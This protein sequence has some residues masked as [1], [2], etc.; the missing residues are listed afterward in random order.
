MSRTRLP[1]HEHFQNFPEIDPDDSLIGPGD[2]PPYM[3]YHDHG[4]APVLLV[5][6]HASPF[7]PASLNQLGLAD[8]VL[9]Q[10][11]A[12]D[13][14]VDELARFLADELD[15]QLVLAG[16]SRL[17]V[18]PNRRPDDPSAIPSISDGIAIPGNQDL[19]EQQRARRLHSFFWPY[20]NAI[21]ERLDRFSERGVVP[22]V[23]AVH[24]CTPV[25]DR[26]VRPWHIGVMWDKD[27][28]IPVPLIE[29]FDRIP[30][31]CIGDNEPYSGRHPHDFTIDFHAETA[32]FPHV[33]FEVRQDLV[34]SREGAREWAGVLARGLD[35]ILSDDDLYR[36]L[37]EKERYPGD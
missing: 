27:P 26:V 4:S 9:E 34:D 25:F 16:F 17:I 18:D 32:G 8:W 2:P 1:G 10:H 5:A 22:A 23:I 21:T 29:H 30:E 19:D 14:G 35:G 33:G 28:R 6:D 12:W 11:V 20:H 36:L 7:F 37:P 3:T 15:A 24:T 31:I 13:V